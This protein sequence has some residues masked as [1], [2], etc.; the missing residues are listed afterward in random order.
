MNAGV[1]SLNSLDLAIENVGL[2]ISN[3]RNA[4]LEKKR[5]KAR[6]V[7]WKKKYPKELVQSYKEKFY[8]VDITGTNH[9]GYDRFGRD[10]LVGDIVGLLSPSKSGPFKGER[11]GIVLDI[12][13]NN[14]ED[15]FIGKISDRS[16]ITKREPHNVQVVSACEDDDMEIQIKKINSEL[17]KLDR[18]KFVNESWK[19]HKYVVGL[20]RY[21]QP[22]YMFDKVKLL[23]VSKSGSFGGVQY[24]LVV[25]N[26]PT[27][28]GKI[29]IGKIDNLSVMTDREPYNLQVI[30][31]EEDDCD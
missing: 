8:S 29:T 24:G 3:L 14:S 1:T 6:I 28:K 7:E 31:V 22:I 15:I 23:S 25:K 20:D 19:K 2:E 30:Y 11:F 13:R 9:L 5:R 10:I 27:N 17:V 21:K 12:V 18:K 26:T 16:I 4:L